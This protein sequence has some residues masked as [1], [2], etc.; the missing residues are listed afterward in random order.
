M[1]LIQFGSYIKELRKKKGLTLA[2]LS[3]L[4]GVSHP[5]LSQIENGK[6]KNFPSPEILI[7]I[8][9]PLDVRYE[10]L[11]KAAGHLDNEALHDYYEH[12]VKLHEMTTK[13][14]KALSTN[15]YFFE[16]VQ[17]KIFKIFLGNMSFEPGLEDFDKFYLEYL[18]YKEEEEPDYIDVELEE[19]FIKFYNYNTVLKTLTVELNSK[20]F[21]WREEVLGKLTELA[22]ERINPSSESIETSNKELSFFLE[23]PNILYKTHRLSKQ[24]IKLLESFLDTLIMDSLKSKKIALTL[25]AQGNSVEEIS[26]IINESPETIQE[27]TIKENK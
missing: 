22:L 13:V 21:D 4:S 15:G 1:D 17:I 6:L 18:R 7:K 24:Q 14:L 20:A 11:L 10:K 19:A 2:S 27:W 25:F 26:K 5:Y 16:D 9:E 3:A 12:D 8:S 23:Q